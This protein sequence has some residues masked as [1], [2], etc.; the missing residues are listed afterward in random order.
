[1]LSEREKQA[2]VLLNR[3]LLRH[4]SWSLEDIH[5]LE[6]VIRLILKDSREFQTRLSLLESERDRLVED[7]KS[8]KRLVQSYYDKIEG[9]DG[10]LAEVTDERDRYRKAL[11]DI[12]NVYDL[13]R[14]SAAY[15]IARTAL[16]SSQ[17]E[18]REVIGTDFT[19]GK[20]RCEIYVKPE[21]VVDRPVTVE[22]LAKVLFGLAPATI[23]TI[24]LNDCRIMVDRLLDRFD[25]RCK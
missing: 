8:L 18:G 13:N 20:D 21:V 2:E 19:Q 9:T 3:V 12:R 14:Q 16:E 17:P 1:M 15:D 24:T 5:D 23:E 22:E 4:D 6:E 7:N 10:L 11:V 25:V